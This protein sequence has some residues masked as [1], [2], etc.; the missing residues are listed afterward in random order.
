MIII[1]NY[2]QCGVNVISTL[3][4]CLHSDNQSC[5]ISRLTIARIFF[6]YYHLQN[7]MHRNTYPVS[8]A[9][10]LAVLTAVLACVYAQMDP[11]MGIIETIRN[12]LIP[13]WVL[14]WFLK[15][16]TSTVLHLLYMYI[17]GYVHFWWFKVLSL[18][19]AN[20]LLQLSALWAAIQGLKFTKIWKAAIKVRRSFWWEVMNLG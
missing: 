2:T 16:I 12:H 14:I 13:S 17:S 7:R 18:L 3:V 20:N 10:W 6:Y 15:L 5:W 4:W 11:S 1:H 9:T 19:Y 8:P